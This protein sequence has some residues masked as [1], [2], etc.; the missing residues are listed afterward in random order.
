MGFRSKGYHER[1][2]ENRAREAISEDDASGKDG[3]PEKRRSHKK[4]GP[5]I[6]RGTNGRNAKRHRDYEVVSHRKHPIQVP[7]HKAIKDNEQLEYEHVND[8]GQPEKT[9]NDNA[10]SFLVPLF[11]DRASSEANSIANS[12]QASEINDDDTSLEARLI[13]SA[14][15]QFGNFAL[16]S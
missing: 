8:S 1:Y 6:R 9:V 11:S 13:R 14:K 3:K 10:Q 7:E 16:L 12:A 2:H 4:D 5:E 15:D